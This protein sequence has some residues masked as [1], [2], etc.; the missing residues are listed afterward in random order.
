[1]RL[2][3]PEISAGRL[4]IH[5]AG[6]HYLARVLR[7]RRGDTVV[8]F[9][10]AGQEARA[11]VDTISDTALVL[12]VDEPREV[13]QAA[14]PLTLMLGLLKGEKMDLVVQKATELGA[15]RIVPL[16]TAHA[17]VRLDEERGEARRGR[18]SRIAAEAARQ[19]GRS[20]VPEIDAPTDLASALAA[21][22]PHA[23]RLLLH[24]RETA[25]L[26]ASLEA[27]RPL[28]IVLAVGPEGGFAPE[29]VA[30]ARA[31]GF[32]VVGLGPRVLRAETAAIAA[33]AV[34]RNAVG[35]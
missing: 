20:D 21:A 7:A 14:V 4:E 9:D 29:E 23:L 33:V 6:F 18:W 30:A 10:G 5:G 3:L 27:E 15:T 35:W 13:G 32:V 2:H 17:V 1:M 26:G 24:E 16:K 34:V 25:R 11:V 28:E 31:A 12:T 8:L 22:P 19:S